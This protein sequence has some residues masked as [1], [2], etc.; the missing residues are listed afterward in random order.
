METKVMKTFNTTGK[1]IPSMH[2]MVDIS[3]QVEAAAKLVRR[4]NYFCIN[5][6][7]LYG[8]T[9]TLAL[10]K[11]LLEQEGYAVIRDNLFMMAI[12]NLI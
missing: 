7:R 2:Y 1:C 10:L 9:T 3:Y 12:F 5:R 4:G 6:G 11:K 8:K